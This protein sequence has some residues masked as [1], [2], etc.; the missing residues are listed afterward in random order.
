MN[1]VEVSTCVA[2]RTTH[3]NLNMNRPITERAMPQV[4]C[5]KVMELA[6]RA[7][8]MATRLG[9]LQPVEAGR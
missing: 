2:A 6:L 8:A 5:F 9:N 4:H 7:E 3:I 1:K